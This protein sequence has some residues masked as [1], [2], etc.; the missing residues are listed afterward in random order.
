MP[1][2]KKKLKKSKVKAK[3]KAKSK[4]LLKKKKVKTSKK[5][6]AM[7]VKKANEKAIGRVIH[8]YDRIG[9]AIVDLKTPLS[10]GD[11][12]SVKRGSTEYFVQ[13]VTSMQINHEAVQRAR[14]GDVIGLKV[15]RKVPDGAVVVQP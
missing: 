10:I 7:I 5:K 12:V 1:P 3:A 13:Q 15:N 8:Y 6:V 14:K 4:K 9:V 11:M 2:A